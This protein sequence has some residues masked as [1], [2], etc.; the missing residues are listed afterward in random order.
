MTAKLLLAALGASLLLLQAGAQPPGSYRQAVGSGQINWTEQ[1]IEA[2]GS[3][4]A[5]NQGNPAQQKLMARR[6]AMADAYRKLAEI[7]EGVQVTAETTVHNYVV[8]SDLVH[9]RVQAVLKGAT[10]VGEP[11]LTP[12]GAVELTV[13]LPL[14]G[15]LAGAIELDKVVARQ[16]QGQHGQLP[17]TQPLRLASL[18]L[19]GL[20]PA[21]V[22]WLLARCQRFESPEPGQSSEPEI[23]PTSEPD[24]EPTP[25]PTPEIEPT[26]EPETEP[27]ME[28][29]PVSG[30]PSLQSDNPQQ[31]FTGLVI[32]A[33]GLQLHPSMSPMVRSEAD[34]APQVYV[35]NFPLDIDRVIAEGIVLYYGSLEQA[36]ASQRAGK[37][38]LV[39][40]PIGSDKH[41]VDFVLH[42]QDAA[43]IQAFD[44]RDRFLQKLQVVAVLDQ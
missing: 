44:Q 29:Q 34:Q 21:M 12:D 31:P 39:V 33:R 5:P 15:Q 6:A 35:G 43:Q 4:L 1:Y 3:G 27:T 2:T 22:P 14:M 8:E 38:P 23:G 32:D 10:P 37:H 30:E 11:R 9:T 40:R 24:T 25:E 13:R 36:L 7:V 42:P 41:G 19:G 17:A 18:D 16:Q 26:A 28:P 20:D